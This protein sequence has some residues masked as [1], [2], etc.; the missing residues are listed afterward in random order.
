M[1]RIARRD[2]HRMLGT[3]PDNVMRGFAHEPQVPA[4]ESLL[5]A[6]SSGED[7]T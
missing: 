4:N 7:D 2:G 3:N 5:R 1:T 6:F